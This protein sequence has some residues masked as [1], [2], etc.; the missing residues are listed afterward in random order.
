MPSRLRK[1]MQ[2]YL[3]TEARRTYDT[4]V[5]FFRPLY[6]DWPKEPPAYTQKNEYL[7]GDQMLVAPVV[8]AADKVTQ[9]A[10][11]KIWLPAGEWIEWP[12]GKHFD[13][14]GTGGSQL[15]HRSDSR[16]P[17][18]RGHRSHA[19]AHAAY[20]RKARRSAHR[21]RVAAR[22]GRELELFGL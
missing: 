18:S 8:T 20:R 10:T 22:A 6:Y 19:A 9:L 16:L 1:A 14:P 4:G 15:F 11:E 12:T 17:E 2:P 5:A 21:E 13:G 7:F 3:Y